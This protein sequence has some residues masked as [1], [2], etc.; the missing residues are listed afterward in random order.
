[1]NFS[2]SLTA[3]DINLIPHPGVEWRSF[4]AKV[5]DLAAREP[6]VFCPITQVMKPWIDVKLLS[7]FYV[8]ESSASNSS[9]CVIT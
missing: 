1:M 5:K 7:K 6:K 4:V 9:S 8:A 3:G 2:R